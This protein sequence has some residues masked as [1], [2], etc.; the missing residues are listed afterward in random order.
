MR[1]G[2]M[3]CSGRWRSGGDSGSTWPKPRPEPGRGERGS[4]AAVPPAPSWPRALRAVRAWLSPWTALQRWWAAWSKAPPPPPQQALMNSV[5][6]GHG[7]HL[8][9]PN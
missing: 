8:Y 2:L 6:A 7:L 1:P 3:T 9:I 4:Q 5:A